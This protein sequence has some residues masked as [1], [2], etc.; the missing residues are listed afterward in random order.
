MIQHEVAEKI[1]TDTQKKSF[2]RRLIN[3]NYDIKYLKGVP[4]KCFKPAPKVKSA[5]IQ[6]TA[7]NEKTKI[8]FEKVKI[9]LDEYAAFSRK[10][11]GAISTMLAKK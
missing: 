3:Y 1:Q 9:F 11:L 5:I 8:D 10:T 6:L 7:K 2:L 4:A